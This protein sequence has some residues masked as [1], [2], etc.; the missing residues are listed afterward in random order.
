MFLAD[1]TSTSPCSDTYGGASP[2]SAIE[3]QVIQARADELGPTLRGFVSVH[4]AAWMWL[5]PLGNT[6][7]GDC[8]VSAD[9]DH[10]VSHPIR[11]SLTLRDFALETEFLIVGKSRVDRTT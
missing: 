10:Q 9:Y 11:L 4:T 2:A 8:E 1:G 6:L 7:D 5:H 3:T